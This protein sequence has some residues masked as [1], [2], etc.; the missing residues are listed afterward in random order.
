MVRQLE[1]VA[2]HDLRPEDREI[3]QKWTRELF[4]AAEDEYDWATPDWRVL[5]RVDG[6]LA[7]HAAITQRTVTANSEP[8]R[9]GGIGGVMT[10]PKYQGKGHARAAML[11]AHDFIRDTLHLEF[12]FLFCSS[13]LLH[14]YQRLGW[15]QSEGPVSFAQDDG[16]AH[17]EEEAMVLPLTARPWPGPPVDLNGRPW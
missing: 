10:S 4:G 6:E 5:V 8:A 17:W 2:E 15:R 1:V 9:V 3:I 14:Y 7:A 16:D 12:G 13:K 11:R